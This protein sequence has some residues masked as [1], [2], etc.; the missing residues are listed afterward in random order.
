MESYFYS[1]GIAPQLPYIFLIAS[2]DKVVL[3]SEAD[4][5]FQPLSLSPKFL[6]TNQMYWYNIYMNKDKDI[7]K[8]I[9]TENMKRI[10]IFL[11]I[12][13]FFQT[14]QVIAEQFFP[15]LTSTQYFVFKITVLFDYLFFVFFRL[16]RNK[17]PVFFEYATII[18]VIGS[19]Y[20]FFMVTENHVVVMFMYFNMFLFY[21][22]TVV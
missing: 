16:Y 3:L 9:H 4:L 10:N 11:I 13:M 20:P 17:I 1:T 5:A 8:R 6:V 19:L 2:H 15:H 21:S 22:L 14:A 12:F 18:L 7:I